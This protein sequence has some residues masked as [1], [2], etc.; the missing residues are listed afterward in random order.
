MFY[1][2][3]ENK[4]DNYRLPTVRVHTFI[5]LWTGLPPPSLI[6]RWR[7]LRTRGS[8]YGLLL[9]HPHLFLCCWC[10]VDIG[11]SLSGFSTFFLEGEGTA[12]G[13]T[14][15]GLQLFC[16]GLL[17]FFLRP[18]TSWG[19]ISTSAMPYWFGPYLIRI[20]EHCSGCACKTG[21]RFCFP[22][23][24]LLGWLYILYPLNGHVNILS[25]IWKRVNPVPT[26]SSAWV[27]YRNGLPRNFPVWA[28][29]NDDKVG[30][31]V[32][33]LQPY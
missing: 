7:V 28:H 24:L 2:I 26:C 15:V 14:F 32:L 6:A 1:L 3:A 16:S 13:L 8:E 27:V 23:R 17:F 22:V 33:V 18:S 20:M 25:L 19:W 12:F 4:K 9:G 31:D 5:V 21:L 30:G 29:V 10:G 11:A